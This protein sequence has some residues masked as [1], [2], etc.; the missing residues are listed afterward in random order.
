[1]TPGCSD[2]VCKD[3]LSGRIRDVESFLVGAELDAV[4]QTDTVLEEAQFV[5]RAEI[6]DSGNRRLPRL[7]QSARIRE[8][9]TARAIYHEIVG[10]V[11]RF[12]VR[13]IDEGRHPVGRIDDSNARLRGE[14]GDD[15]P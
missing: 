7:A 12:A 5:S 2:I 9:H 4:R 10:S 14:R 3:V 13:L 1:M 8:I 6:V 15:A 11:Q